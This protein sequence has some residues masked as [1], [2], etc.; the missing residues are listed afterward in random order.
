M[1]IYNL[2]FYTSVLFKAVES[3]NIDIVKLLLTKNILNIN[4]LNIYYQTH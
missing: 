3:N 4:E 2:K 1:K